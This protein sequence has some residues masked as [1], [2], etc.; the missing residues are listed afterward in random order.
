VVSAVAVVAE[1]HALP[2]GSRETH[3]A[4]EEGVRC[5]FVVVCW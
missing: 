2:S 5:N 3:L 1:D 4:E